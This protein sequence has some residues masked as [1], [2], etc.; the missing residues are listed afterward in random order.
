MRT[1][2][3][4]ATESFFVDPSQATTC[5]TWVPTKGALVTSSRWG[6]ATLQCVYSSMSTE[7][8]VQS[9][10][11]RVLYVA[12]PWVV[13]SRGAVRLDICAREPKASCF[14]ARLHDTAVDRGCIPGLSGGLR[15]RHR[16]LVAQY[17]LTLEAYCPSVASDLELESAFGFA[18]ATHRL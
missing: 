14:V 11:T 3:T 16:M 13:P 12:N 18:I 6:L 5:L 9:D 10:Q 4:S 1:G 2:A 8:R 17:L 7:G 15:S